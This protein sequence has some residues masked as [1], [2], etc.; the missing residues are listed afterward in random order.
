MLF[1]SYPFLFAY[2]PITYGLFYVLVQTR[3]KFAIAWLALAS[4]FFYG[5]WKAE[6][7]PLLLFSIVFNF[8]AGSL[9]ARRAQG[10][11]PG[12]GKLILAGSITVNLAL[13]GYFKYAHFFLESIAELTGQTWSLGEIVLPLGISFFTFTQIAFLVDAHR[14]LTQ[15]YRFIDYVL[16]VTYF[17]HLI[18][19]PILH[20]KEMMTQFNQPDTF[21]A[22][23]E[24]AALGLTVFLFGLCKKTV[25]AD[26]IAPYA[27]ALFDTAVRQSPPPGLA[28]SWGGALAYTLQ[29]YFDFSAYSDMA[30]GL[31]LLF[32]IRLPQNF[33][34]P[35]RAV[36]II[37][38][39]RRWHMSL[40]RFLRD[41]LYIPLG[42]NRHGSLRR[43]LNLFATM[44]L[45]GLWHGAN[46]TFVI[47]GGLHGIYL[48]INH[49]SRAL[50]RRLGQDPDQAGPLGRGVSTLL[51]FLAVV[52]G[53]V[54]FRADSLA[55]AR[56]ILR[57]MAGLNGVSLPESWPNVTA[58]APLCNWLLEHGVVFA[59]TP[60]AQDFR[61]LAW[62][63]ILLGICWFC[64]NTEQV[65]AT[66][67]PSLDSF[68]GMPPKT[69]RWQW[70]PTPAW[71]LACLCAGFWAILSIS[72]LSEFIYFQF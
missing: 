32:G 43:Y 42:G 21:R 51:T 22:T 15:E 1:N 14:G 17:P 60:H 39:W 33:Y 5:W 59:G 30:I 63:L 67:R 53:W 55:S 57:G 62:T 26:G 8:A 48:V 11:S 27:R 47:W 54:F 38:F 36:N 29:L 46:W 65:F 10:H 72:E 34:S 28:E 16:F 41:Y 18:A 12:P 70:R 64:P 49:A 61:Q 71:A 45:G 40:S 19:G 50:R 58:L 4:L 35:Y 24:N 2:L 25:L 37:E 13:L 6:F 56:V 23:A 66:Y 68:R 20:H 9:I 3:L 52:V 7:L 44:L 31:S 69:T